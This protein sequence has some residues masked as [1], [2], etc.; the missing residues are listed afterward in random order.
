MSQWWWRSTMMEW[1]MIFF[2]LLFLCVSRS[3]AALPTSWTPAATRRQPP[4]L[5][6]RRRRTSSR[7]TRPVWARHPRPTRPRR[8]PK[9]TASTSQ[10][11]HH[12][13]WYD[14]KVGH[15]V[16][17]TESRIMFFSGTKSL[18]K[19]NLET[20]FDWLQISIFSLSNWLCSHLMLLHTCTKLFS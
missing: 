5:L 14:A 8:D 20:I 1:L 15:L 4:P 6:R 16:F 13:L 18:K 2:S 9:M 12:M 10:V 17:K 11:R 7:A 3:A 19:K